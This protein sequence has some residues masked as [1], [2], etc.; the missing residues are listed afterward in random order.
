MSLMAV[1]THLQM[2]A[3]LAMLAALKG[4]YHCQ[5]SVETN[6]KSSTITPVPATDRA[7]IAATLC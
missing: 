3:A 4:G 5:C 1:V 7:A 6:Y 2:H